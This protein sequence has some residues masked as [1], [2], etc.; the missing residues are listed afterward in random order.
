MKI[1]LTGSKGFVG[2]HLYKVLEKEHDI[3]G[4]EAKLLFRN[5]YDEMCQVIDPSLDAVVHVGAISNNQF[6]GADIYLWNTYATYLIAEHVKRMDTKPI[7]FIFFSSFLVGATAND[8]SKRTPYS[9]SKAQSESYLNTYL[10]D[11]AI[12]RPCVMWGD[13]SNKKATLGSVPWRLASHSL[14]YLIRNWKRKYVH[15]N[16]VVDA[17]KICLRDNLKG[18]FDVAPDEFHTSEALAELIRWDG[19]KWTDNPLK[20]LGM[21][22]ISSHTN[23]DL[24][25]KIPKWEPKIRIED[26]LPRLEGSLFQ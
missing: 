4:L 1:L 12:L 8:W 6:T 19:Y 3:V 2:S 22:F 15:I 11:A 17:V 20:D 13:E 7:Q 21:N 26:E 9:W 18:A 16:D 10:S 23:A 14:E 24:V 25:S 5:W